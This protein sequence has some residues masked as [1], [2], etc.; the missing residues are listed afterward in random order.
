MQVTPQLHLV[1]P[2][3]SVDEQRPD[4]ENPGKT[5]AVTVPLLWVYHTPISAP[6]FQA[7]YRIISATKAAIYSKGI[8]YAVN[9]GPRIAALTLLDVAKVD[10]AEW[11]TENTARAL[12][13]EISRLS[14]IL[15]PKD[16]EQKEGLE[17]VPLDIAVQREV[18][19]PEEADEAQ[20]ALVFFTCGY[21]MARRAQREATARF[22]ATFALSG[23][24][25]SLTPTEY[26]ASLQISTPEETSVA[27]AQSSHPS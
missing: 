23:S 7:Y 8:S 18:I 9:N 22:L 13:A 16:K 4:K 24:I 2:V 15:V 11:D 6:V 20:A 26:V 14:F 27:A 17:L 19:D 1:F 21:A 5:I 3:R 25:T 10:A 12:L